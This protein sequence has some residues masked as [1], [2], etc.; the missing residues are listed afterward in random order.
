VGARGEVVV[1]AS[2]AGDDRAVGL[3]RVAPSALRRR[4]VARSAIPEAQ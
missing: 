4:S 2:L 3:M 1:E